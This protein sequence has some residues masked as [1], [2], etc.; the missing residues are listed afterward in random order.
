MKKILTFLIINIYFIYPLLL[1]ATDVEIIQSA[2]HFTLINDKVRVTIDRKSGDL[3]SIIFR[4]LELMGHDSGHPAGYWEQDPSRSHHLI[5]CVSIDPK[6]NNGERAE[7]SIKGTSDGLVSLGAGPGGGTLCDI[8]LRY[9]LGREDSGIYTYA[10]YTHPNN[11]PDTLI[12]ESRF[13]VK[14]NSHVFDWLSI[15]K[16]RN[17]LMLTPEDWAKGTQLNMKEARLINTGIY[18]GQVEHKYDYSALQYSIPAFGWSSTN[19]HVGFWFINPSMEY[20]SGGPTKVELTGH[21]DLTNTADPTLLDYWRGT[22]YG[23]S[24]L[25]L[26]AGELWSKVVGPIYIYCNEAET[27]NTM[28]KDALN[29]AQ[30]ESYK[31]PYQWVKGVDYPSSIQRSKVSGHIIISD[32]QAPN[33]KP[34]NMY[35]GLSAPDWITNS[36]NY[37]GT[38]RQ[39]PVTWQTDAKYYQ[40]W[41]HSDNEGNFILNNVRPG[42]Y[43][44]HAFSDGVLGE[45]KKADITVKESEV[46]DLGKIIWKPVRFGKQIWDIGIANRSAKEFAHG[47]DFWHWGLYCKYAEWFPDDVHYVIGRSN[48]ANDWNFEQVPHATKYDSSGHAHGHATSWEISFNLEDKPQGN[49]TL[50]LAIV[51]VET[52]KIDVKVNGKIAGQVSDLT[53]NAVLHRDGIQGTWVE[54][55]IRF[56]ASLLKAGNNTLSLTIPAGPVTSGIEYDYLRL[57]LDE[58]L[59]P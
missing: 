29:Q 16:D 26:K 41:V 21:L 25:T 44:L 35:V 43:T 39:I 54:K 15:D 1:R 48:F 13:G 3:V 45:Y 2:D 7:V 46:L 12:G 5:S 58:S 32:P 38:E 47:N 42:R 34:S 17:K 56:S 24:V 28:W 52:S 33:L 50:R 8:E 49:A 27:P 11:Y 37:H 23:G 31:W 22:H 20:L 55:D 14:L 40:F 19:K 59:K 9:S 30:K 36:R 53:P 4:D 6:F 51:G 57:E 18:K 10:I